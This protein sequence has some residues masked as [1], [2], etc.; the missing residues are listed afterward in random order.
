MISPLYRLKNVFHF[1]KKENGIDMLQEKA[2]PNI[3]ME[4]IND[5]NTGG[6]P[7]I[8]IIEGSTQNK[9]IGIKQRD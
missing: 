8:E 6:T 5:L 9:N 2:V 3:I 1:L 7:K 4:I